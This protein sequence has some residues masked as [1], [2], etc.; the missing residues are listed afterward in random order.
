MKDAFREMYSY[1][2]LLSGNIFLSS[3]F[4]MRNKRRLTKNGI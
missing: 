4:L 2:K 3:T 1:S